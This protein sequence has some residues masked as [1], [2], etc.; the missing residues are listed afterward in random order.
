MRSDYVKVGEYEILQWRRGR[1]YLF[2]GAVWPADFGTLI[3]LEAS[4]SKVFVES[5]LGV[6]D[7]SSLFVVS[8]EC[9]GLGS[10]LRT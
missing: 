3:P 2:V 6:G 7:G 4:P 5:P 10:R 8:C 9:F 1:H